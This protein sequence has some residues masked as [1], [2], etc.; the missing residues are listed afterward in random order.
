MPTGPDFPLATPSVLSL[1][2]PT[3]GDKQL[4]FFLWKILFL[5]PQ[6]TVTLERH[7]TVG[8]CPICHLPL[9]HREY[10]RRIIS[11]ICVALKFFPLKII[12]FQHSHKDH[13]VAKNNIFRAFFT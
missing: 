4:M 7:I 10:Q 2:V 3:G 1:R 11:T 12:S 9:H 6:R 13:I 8:M 5:L